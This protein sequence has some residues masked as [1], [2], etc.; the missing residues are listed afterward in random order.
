LS[1]DDILDKSTKIDDQKLLEAKD[2][3]LVEEKRVMSP[4]KYVSNGKSTVSSSVAQVVIYSSRTWVPRDSIAESL[5][6]EDTSDGSEFL[7]TG[8]R[9]S[10]LS[11]VCPKDTQKPIKALSQLRNSARYFCNPSNPARPSEDTSHT[12][13]ASTSWSPLLPTD[14]RKS[15]Q[16]SSHSRD[17]TVKLPK[18]SLSVGDYPSRESPDTSNQG[19]CHRSTSRPLVR[20]EMETLQEFLSR[21]VALQSR[22]GSEECSSS[23]RRITSSNIQ[24]TR[25]AK[26]DDVLVRGEME[27]MQEYLSRKAAFQLQYRTRKLCNTNKAR[28]NSFSQADDASQDHNSERVGEKEVAF[29]RSRANSSPRTRSERQTSRQ[30]LSGKASLQPRDGTDKVV[31]NSRKRKPTTDLEDLLTNRKPGRNTKAA[32]HLRAASNRKA[33]YGAN[34]INGERFALNPISRSEIKGFKQCFSLKDLSQARD[35]AGKFL[36]SNKKRRTSP[37]SQEKGGAQTPEGAVDVDSRDRSHYSR[38]PS[39]S[40]AQTVQRHVL[41]KASSQPRDRIGKFQISNKKSNPNLEDDVPIDIP[42]QDIR[43]S[44][45]SQKLANATLQ[46]QNIPKNTV[47]AAKPTPCPI[48]ANDR[49]TSDYPPIDSHDWQSI[50][51]C[52]NLTMSDVKGPFDA[53]LIAPKNLE[54]IAGHEQPHHQT[55]YPHMLDGSPNISLDGVNARPQPVDSSGI[56]GSTAKSKSSSDSGEGRS[57]TSDIPRGHE[58]DGSKA[59]MRSPSKT[60]EAP[61][62]YGADCSP[63]YNPNQDCQFP[64][65][66][67]FISMD[68]QSML[69]PQPEK[70]SGKSAQTK[71]FFKRALD[72][73]LGQALRSDKPNPTTEALFSPT[74]TSLVNSVTED[75]TQANDRI[76]VEGESS[77]R[78]GESSQKIERK[79]AALVSPFFKPIN[80]PAK[81]SKPSY[82]DLEEP[83]STLKRIPKSPRTPRTPRGTVSCIPFPPLS[84]PAFGLI[85]ERLAHN[86]FRLLIA[87]TFLIKTRGKDAI[88][89]FFELMARFPTPEALA[90]ADREDII[91]IIHHLGLQ[92]Q[93]AATYQTYAQIWVKAPPEKG[94]RYAVPGYP[95]KESGRKIKKDEILDD[96]DEREAWEIGHMT[97]GAYALDSWRI[98][99]RDMLRG[100]AKGWNGEG[101]GEGFQPE[102][103]RVLP[104]DK[105]LRAY[106]RWMWLK[107]G[108]EWDPCTGEKEVASQ[109]MMKAAMKGNIAWDSKGGMRIVFNLE[110]S[111]VIDLEASD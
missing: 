40:E 12:S 16:I 14:R 39:W 86:P 64:S 89:V 24:A 105:E 103:M 104:E 90:S 71:N 70:P 93:R 22:D 55:A 92:N 13:H 48:V 97:Q 62:Q 52:N 35:G 85:Q 84:V 31:S 18:R 63:F 73:L 9:H 5:E 58:L 34:I 88:P 67:S 87:V 65:T 32:E 4:K 75:T 10:A 110:E 27:T 79:K 57:K 61:Q 6:S 41:L 95:T 54:M 19:S 106:L 26:D 60:L 82:P 49:E 91:Q 78:K 46:S 8:V 101:A 107:E 51:T 94:K 30:H 23:W 47:T 15:I 53:S 68:N 98:F 109:E 7:P 50:G 2:D 43:S 83:L 69:Y 28:R 3:S 59:H 77:E 1:G 111:E 81:G 74:I 108:F 29:V 36:S 25:E 38:S 80:S 102:W 45:L 20:G 56:F 33:N 96:E 44:Q 100:V 99:C 21:K 66:P 42:S 37:R 72:T 11:M 17:P 76:L